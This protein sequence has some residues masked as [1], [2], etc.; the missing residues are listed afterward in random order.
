[1]TI[2]VSGISTRLFTKAD[3]DYLWNSMNS[4]VFYLSA[5]YKS[6]VWIEDIFHELELELRFLWIQMSLIVTLTIAFPRNQYHLQRL[7]K[8]CRLSCNWEWFPQ[9][10][11]PNNERKKIER[12]KEAKE[13]ELPW[14]LCSMWRLVCEVGSEAHARDKG[15][16][17]EIKHPG[18]IYRFE[19]KLW[20]Q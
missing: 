7:K 9:K 15:S 16:Q 12:G 13:N 10:L 4:V 8:D 3:K 11:Q 2:S 20:F 6:S 18:S 19:K 14:I 17:Y 1:M 5:K